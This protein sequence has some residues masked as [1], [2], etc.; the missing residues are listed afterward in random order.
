MDHT[1]DFHQDRYTE[2]KVPGQAPPVAPVCAASGSSLDSHASEQNRIE[3]NLSA[4][5]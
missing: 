4:A 3:A 2:K 5:P 1:D